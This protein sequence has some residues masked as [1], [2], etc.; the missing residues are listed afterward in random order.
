MTS[1]DLTHVLVL[2]ALPAEFEAVASKL[3]NRKP[4]VGLSHAA[5]GWIPSAAGVKLKVMVAELGRGN[6]DAAAAT[7][8]ILEK[9]NPQVAL[10]CGIA[11]GLKD[12]CHGDVVAART[13]VA[14]SLVKEDAHQLTRRQTYHSDARLCEV[15]VG[16]THDNLW[17]RRLPRSRSG[18]QPTALVDPIAS[19]DALIKNLGSEAAAMVRTHASDCVVLDM[20]S[21]GFMRAAHE[22]DIG[23]L[24]IRGISDFGFD[25]EAADESGSQPMAAT[26]AAAFLI[27]LVTRL[28]PGAGLPH[29]NGGGQDGRNVEAEPRWPAMV[30][31]KLQLVRARDETSARLVEGALTPDLRPRDSRLARLIQTPPK[32]LVDAG[33]DVWLLVA[34]AALAYELPALAARALANAADLGLEPS[35]RWLATAAFYAHG[36]NEPEFARELMARARDGNNV[37]A[38]VGLIGGVLEDDVQAILEGAAKAEPGNDEER[39]LVATLAANAKEQ[40]GDWDAAN[41]EIGRLRD[42]YPDRSGLWITTG[43]LMMSRSRRSSP[44]RDQDIVEAVRCFIHARDLRR[45]WN[46]DSALPAALAASAQIDRGEFAAALQVTDVEPAGDATAWEGTQAPVIELSTR[47][48]LM[49]GRLEEA[50]AK[51]DNLGDAYTKSIYQGLLAKR[52]AGPSDGA[53]QAFNRALETASTVQQRFAALYHLATLGRDIKEGEAVLRSEDPELADQVLAASHSARGEHQAA[54]K[55]LRRA[56]SSSLAGAEALAHAHLVAEEDQDAARILVEAA[57]RFNAPNLLVEAI[58]MLRLSDPAE[59]RRIAIEA[60][61][62]LRPDSDLRRQVLRRLLE[63]EGREG[64]WEGVVTVARTLLSASGQD[65]A[66]AEKIR[67]ALVVGLL[68]LSRRNDA[69]SVMEAPNLLVPENDYQAHVQIEILCKERPGPETITRLVELAERFST[70]ESVRAAALQGIYTMGSTEPL[71]PDRLARLHAETARFFQEHASSQL[72]RQIEVPNEPEQML[73][74]LDELIPDIDQG[75][76][77]LESRVSSGELPVG[78]LSTAMHKPYMATLIAKGRML[79]AFDPIL[80][81]DE[82][83]IAGDAVGRELVV[84]GSALYIAS[85]V[86]GWWENVLSNFARVY[87]ADLAVRDMLASRD[88]LS[89]RSNLSLVRG[90][91]GKVQVHQM[92]PEMA[93]AFAKRSV[94]ALER[95]LRLRQVSIKTLPRFDRFD[96]IEAGAWLGNLQLAADRS[97]SLLCDDLALR[98]LAASVGIKSFS[99][100]GLMQR[101]VARGDINGSDLETWVRQLARAAVA[102]LPFSRLRV[103][104]LA[105]EDEYKGGPALWALGRPRAW[106]EPQHALNLYSAAVDNCPKDDPRYLAAWLTAVLSG[107]SVTMPSKKIRFVLGVLMRAWQSVNLE[108]DQ[109]PRLVSAVDAADIAIDRAEV[110]ASLASQMGETLKGSLD[111]SRSV[112]YIMSRLAQLPDSD[113]DAG[114]RRLLS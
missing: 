99:S 14:Y 72:L 82:E 53:I 18:R 51:L 69:A 5:S 13:V 8:R 94:L 112:A 35:R 96:P 56:A 109:L 40:I 11:M 25:K 87:V 80:L 103:E 60:L 2:T 77:E 111:H 30:L 9:I 19:G 76:S 38:F 93:E 81:P 75:L 22:V 16:L 67:W 114:L 48:L 106:L 42:L 73:A 24:V 10:F 4:T 92:P 101:L 86:E 23:A 3:R 107:A 7:T 71:E 50:R 44:T 58:D 74:R 85:L 62:E 6:V 83:A 28:G 39:I 15:A 70:S 113:R 105:S 104:E 84:D 64:N 26:A 57:K 59:V 55:I 98:R 79:T 46:G 49:M 63:L 61:G 108:P 21:A 78:L 97:L 34:Y 45:L 41:V 1:E 102:D 47:A 68:H 89:L 100:L 90:P 66:G 91:D 52:Y 32:W 31:R 20:E 36:G 54:I 29:V 12:V 27:E 37:D 95:G 65:G 17:R 110:V 88:E 33:P 43:N